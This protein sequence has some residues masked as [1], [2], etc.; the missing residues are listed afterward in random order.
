MLPSICLEFNLIADSLFQSVLDLSVKKNPLNNFNEIN[1][2]CIGL[3]S[4]WS[5][6]IW[7]LWNCGIE[8]KEQSKMKALHV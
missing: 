6:D 5:L 7:M 3:V 2:L 4:G 1:L 8:V